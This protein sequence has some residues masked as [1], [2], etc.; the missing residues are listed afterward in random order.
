MERAKSEWIVITGGPSSG[1][2]TILRC[3]KSKGYLVINEVAR[4]VIDRANR[5]GI[6]TQELRRDEIRFQESMLPIK[7]RLERKLPRR[8]VIFLNRGMPDSVAYLL[9]CGG[10]PQKAKVLCERNLYRRVFLLEQLPIFIEDY[11]RTENLKDAKKISKLLRQAYEELGYHVILVPSMSVER[12]IRF[13]LE[14]F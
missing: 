8:K 2:K 7:A 5:Q 12:R 11:A 9:N 13:I 1:K 6:R 10:D 14:L 4:G 3:F